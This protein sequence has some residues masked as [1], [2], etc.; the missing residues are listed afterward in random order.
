MYRNISNML[1]VFFAVVLILPAFQGE[2]FLSG[3]LRPY[4]CASDIDPAG[5]IF[6]DLYGSEGATSYRLPTCEVTC[7]DPTKTLRM[8]SDVCP[9]GS[10]PSCDATVRASLQKWKTDMVN[11]KN[12]LTQKWCPGSQGK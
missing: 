3:T 5:A 1:F 7:R 10:L 2:G 8:P 11:R 12:Y 6:C 4:Y 9:R